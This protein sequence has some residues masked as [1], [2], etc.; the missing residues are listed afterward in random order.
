LVKQHLQ[1]H[2]IPIES[3]LKTAPTIYK[4]A[5]KLEKRFLNEW[6]AFQAKAALTPET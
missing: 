5:M 2:A 1:V 3:R 6:A 4:T